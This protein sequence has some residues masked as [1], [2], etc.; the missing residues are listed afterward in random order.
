MRKKDLK[1]LTEFIDSGNPK[2]VLNFAHV[3]DGGIFATD[4][5]IAIKFHISE[6]QSSS[7]IHKKLLKGFESTMGKDDVAS[8]N[9]A[10]TPFISCNDVA[11]SLDTAAVELEPISIEHVLDKKMSSSFTVKSLDKIQFE[12]SSRLC[13]I[14][15]NQ[16]A[17]IIKLS[18]AD[19]YEVF[20]NPQNERNS[21]MARIVAY[22]EDEEESFKPLYT[23]MIMGNLF[24]SEAK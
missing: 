6:L 10:Q 18:E 14:N 21:G 22:I 9:V 8:F 15:Y 11:L 5:R 17:D 23:A 16:L 12:L 20:Y 13:Y 24:D 2:K 1:L 7:F 4:T 19:K 3:R